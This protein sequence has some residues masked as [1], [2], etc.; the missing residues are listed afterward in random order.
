VRVPRGAARVDGRGKFL[1]PGLVEMHTHLAPGA[2]LPTDPAG[3]QLALM[4]ANGI[5]T[6]RG[7]IAPP[8][9]LALRERVRRGEVLGPE[10]LV[11]GPSVNGQSAPTPAEAVRLVTEARAAGYDL[12]KTHGGLT[13]EAYDSM[14]ATAQRLGLRVAGHVTQGYGLAHAMASGQQVEHHDG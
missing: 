2:G 10:L 11:A 3:R 7:L 9:Y 1:M 6:A 12:I 8:G 13:R 4:L 5:T 14:I